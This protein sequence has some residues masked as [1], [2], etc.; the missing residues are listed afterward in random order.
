MKMRNSLKKSIIVGTVLT[1]AITPFLPFG[2]QQ[3]YAHGGSF[4]DEYMALRPTLEEFGAAVY[5]DETSK[6][7]QVV[8]DGKVAQLQLNSADAKV[9]GTL[10]TLA[11]PVV[12]KNGITYVYHDFIN[13]IF[14]SDVVPSVQISKDSNPLNPLTAQEIEKAVSIVK[15]SEG[16][17]ETILFTEISLK[18]PAKSD[19]WSYVLAGE[20]N[21]LLPRV[22][23]FV[24]LDGKYVIE[25]EVNLADGKLTKWETKEG[26]QGMVTLDDMI[27][28]QS[29]IERN[30][31]YAEAI[32]KRG[33]SD[34]KKV[35]TTP[36]T[37]GYFGGEDDLVEDA[38][39][40]K[41]V[42]YLDTGDGNFWAHPIEDLVAVVDLEKKQI[43]KIEDNGVIPVPMQAN[44]YDGR[45]F[46]DKLAQKPLTIDE[47]A[48]KNYNLT[49]NMISWGNWDF[50]LRLDSRVG[51]ILSTMTYNDQGEK[52][53]IMY[54]G[55]L[56]GMVVPYGDPDIG[57][58]F[59][60]Y[61]DSGEYGMGT[62]TSSLVKGKDVPNNAVLLDAVTADTQ[63]NPRTIPNAMAVFEQYAGPEYRHDTMSAQGTDSKERRELV[64]R[65]ISTVGNYDYIFDWV[66]QP[67]GTIKID[68]GA[69][70]IE[71]VK[72][73]VTTNMHD[74]SATEDTKYGTLL[75]KN[76]V[77]T[78]HQHIYNFRLDMDVDGENNSLTEIDPKVAV[79][80]DGGPRKSVMITEHKTVKTEQEATQKFDPS[81]IRI[82]SNPNKENKVGNQVSYQIIPFAGGTHPIAKGALFSADDWLFKRAGFM[83][84]QIW[85]TTYNPDER[86]P[87]GK[88]PNRTAKD[89]GLGEFT[90]DN[91]SIENTDDVVWITTGATHVARAEEWPIMPTEWV[92]AMLKPWNFFDN[93]PTMNLP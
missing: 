61:F 57:W 74:A 75:D 5:W 18:P 31:A 28:V 12:M 36:L 42:S 93:T 48:G 6:T 83:D 53:K 2:S 16:Y 91:A 39:L 9:N 14:Q 27:T 3:A 58:Y 44:P 67:N 13:A 63:G 50:H 43:I 84:K 65:W 77:G 85:V 11:G 56:G 49:G 29:V 78:T 82:L 32:A 46:A 73:V 59:K 20:R 23:E 68:V 66:L 89:T 79:N 26:A 86:Y 87:E 22:A 90:A 37:V 24:A 1:M 76:I 33:I 38:R 41:V 47:S 71:A 52:R 34:I 55:S 62:L 15:G 88:Y 81:T 35:V 70:G 45:N 72:G 40:L 19:V 8:K 30:A 4:E 10:R 92:H 51:P 64:V 21:K 80:M 54:E 25:G 7:I 17:K 69:S 60:T